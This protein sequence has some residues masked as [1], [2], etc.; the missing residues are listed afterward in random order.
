MTNKSN[1]PPHQDIS[2]PH[3]HWREP[4]LQTC[5][6]DFLDKQGERKDVYGYF[7]ISNYNWNTRVHS[8]N[9][10]QLSDKYYGYY[11]LDEVGIHHVIHFMKRRDM[12]ALTQLALW[13]GHEFY[14]GSIFSRKGEEFLFNRDEAI[15]WLKGDI[16]DRAGRLVSKKPEKDTLQLIQAL[17]EELLLEVEETEFSLPALDSGRLKVTRK[18]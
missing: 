11:S 6:K 16:V 4:N 3:N 15:S 8:Y 18:R 14:F 10:L 12:E 13:A 2:Q 17:P 7:Q 9:C 5:I 1:L